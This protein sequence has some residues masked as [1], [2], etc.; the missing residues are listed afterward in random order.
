MPQKYT[1]TI[2]F[3]K[4]NNFITMPMQAIKEILLFQKLILIINLHLQNI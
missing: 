2:G 3:D 1:D 4:I